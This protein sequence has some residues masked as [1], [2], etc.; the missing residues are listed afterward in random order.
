MQTSNPQNEKH[1]FVL[2]GGGS[3]GAVQ[4]GMLVELIA[5]GQRPD[6]IVGVSAGALNGAF[7][8]YDPTETTMDL[9]SVLWSSVRTR[10]I[11]PFSVGLLLGLIG[12]RGHLA[13]S[14]GVRQL[15]ERE[16]PFRQ[17]SATRVPLVIVAAE[18]STGSEVLISE[19]NVID[20][21]LA[22]S[23][24]PGVFP[25][26]EL[27]GRTLVDGVVAV[28]TPISTA[29]ALG[30]TRLTIVPCGFTCVQ[31][32][33]PRHAIGRAMHA[34]ALLGARQLRADFSHFSDRAQLCFVPPLCPLACSPY[35][36]SQG[37][38]LIAAARLSTRQW[39]DGGGLENREFPHQLMSHQH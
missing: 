15:L 2:A 19:G 5:N 34:I 24:I 6:L 10:D 9:L 39:I 12:W 28:G 18:Q 33:V 31:S 14:H 38:A 20:A 8:A 21:I 23:A 17:F 4:V 26:V 11:L 7:L 37:A 3:L 25:P 1:A 30:S 13:D 36:Y 29:V 16:L 22:S 32:A 27:G 35:D